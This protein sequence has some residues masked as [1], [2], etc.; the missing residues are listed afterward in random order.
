MGLPMSTAAV[1]DRLKA[2]PLLAGLG[3]KELDL[4]ASAARH[5]SYR[6]NAR[7]FEEGSSAD[8]CYVLTSGRAK[9][10]LNSEDGAE[11]LLGDL[12]E[13]D[14]VGELA[15][16]DGFARS[17]ALVAIEPCHFLLI[18]APAFERLRA[19]AAFER[20][21]VAQL[22]SILRVRSEHVRRVATGP[23]I[24]RVAWCLGQI[25]HRE[26]WR[27]GRSIVIPRKPHQ[28]LAG[29]AGCTRETVSRAL[30]ALKQ[31]RSVT[32]DAHTMR[33]DMNLLQR[34]IRTEIGG[35]EGALPRT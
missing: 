10:V 11:V 5:V 25:A 27:D 12:A 30:A 31:K 13:G 34:Y 17:A 7:I 4:L 3:D 28:E 20:K 23:S 22:A 33:L 8:C 14:L 2:V 19:N 32:W 1:K 29:M 6:K 16:L 24:A 26:G 15:L 9:V 21:L 35:V 18:P